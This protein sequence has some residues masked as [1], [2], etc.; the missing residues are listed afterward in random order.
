M[1]GWPARSRTVGC[2]RWLR[3]RR[4]RDAA[5]GVLLA[6][7]LAAALWHGHRHAPPARVHGLVEAIEAQTPVT[8]RVRAEATEAIDAACLYG[9]DLTD[10]PR[11]AAAWLAG[12]LIGRRVMLIYPEPESDAALVYRDDGLF[13]NEHLVDRGLAR[14]DP[15]AARPWARWFGRVERRARA[16]GRGR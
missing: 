1:I 3:R 15:G 12:A 5:A 4:R 9:C 14:A 13:L 2:D 6:G 8:L 10:R 11:E 7:A 16:D